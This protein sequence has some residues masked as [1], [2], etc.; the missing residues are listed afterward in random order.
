[1]L[2]RLHRVS[3]LHHFLLHHLLLHHQFLLLLLQALQRHLPLVFQQLLL[4]LS[5]DLEFLR[6]GNLS[7]TLDFRRF[8]SAA[9]GVFLA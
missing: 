4:L 6:H 3:L 7:L 5:Q 8:A 2:W 9:F 1:M